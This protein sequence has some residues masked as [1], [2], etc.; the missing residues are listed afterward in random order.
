MIE[1]VEHQSIKA[2]ADASHRTIDAMLSDAITAQIGEDWEVN[3]LNGRLAVR[4]KPSEYKIFSLDGVDIL[5]LL[6]GKFSSGQTDRGQTK[7]YYHIKE[8]KL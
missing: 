7:F 2:L 4:I 5:K 6:P 1:G 8:E 3:D